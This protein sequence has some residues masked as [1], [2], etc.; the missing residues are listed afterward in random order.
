MSLRKKSS[1]IQKQAEALDEEMGSLFDK[2]FQGLRLEHAIVETDYR[3]EFQDENTSV[4]SSPYMIV[5]SDNDK[6]ILENALDVYKFGDGQAQDE[7]E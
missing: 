5:K 7:Q 4:K 2:A 1:L 3:H 6:M